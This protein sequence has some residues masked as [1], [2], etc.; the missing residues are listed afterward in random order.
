MSGS[1]RGSAGAPMAPILA[2]P[3][4]AYIRPSPAHPTHQFLRDWVV[5]GVHAPRREVHCV[6]GG[7]QGD[8]R[9]AS[10]SG[11][12]RRGHPSGSGMANGG[13]RR[14][15]LQKSALRL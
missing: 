4:Q 2:R 6:H 8:E 10:V 12:G 15:S 9:R 13:Q 11:A 14:N 5:L 7:E 1:K 3:G